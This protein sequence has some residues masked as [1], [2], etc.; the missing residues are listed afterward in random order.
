MSPNA[1]I[2]KTAEPRTAIASFSVSLFNKNRNEPA[3]ELELQQYRISD[4]KIII[5]KQRLANKENHVILRMKAVSGD[6]PQSWSV[7]DRKQASDSAINFALVSDQLQILLQGYPPHS[8]P[9]T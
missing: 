8:T 9:A 2:K 7:I 4:I 6:I 5:E 1:G 3:I